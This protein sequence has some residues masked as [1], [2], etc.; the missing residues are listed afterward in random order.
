MLNKT[1]WCSF[2]YLEF[3]LPHDCVLDCSGPGPADDAVAYWQPRLNLNLNREKMISELR[4]YGAW[5]QEELA[6]LSNSDL[7]QKLIW[8]AANDIRESEDI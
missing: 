5:E 1:Y 7:E 3:K 4:E 6:S 2:N 8:L